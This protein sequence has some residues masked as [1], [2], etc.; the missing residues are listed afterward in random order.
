M[1]EKI[2]KYVLWLK[3]INLEINS[4]EILDI[5]KYIKMTNNKRGNRKDIK[6]SLTY[7]EVRLK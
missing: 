5:H 7:T 6:N 4:K 3:M 2:I 1:I